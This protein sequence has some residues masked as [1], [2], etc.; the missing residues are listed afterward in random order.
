MRKARRPTTRA[1]THE[2][3]LRLPMQGLRADVAR[4]ALRVLGAR[5]RRDR[6]CL[7]LL[8]IGVVLLG[9]T[10]AL[11]F[12]TKLVVPALFPVLHLAF[13]SAVAGAAAP[14]FLP[15]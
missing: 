9:A 12:L 2:A 15:Q 5:L 11:Y 13:R 14:A 6:D 4:L 8:G 7:R 3:L 10:R 1:P